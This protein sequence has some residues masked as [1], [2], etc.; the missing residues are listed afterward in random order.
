MMTSAGGFCASAAACPERAVLGAAT[1]IVLS[2][3]TSNLD[4]AAEWFD[5]L[6]AGGIEGLIVKDG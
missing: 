2:Q 1:Q 5:T 3:Q 4:T 6:T